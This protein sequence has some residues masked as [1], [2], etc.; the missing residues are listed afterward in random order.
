MTQKYKGSCHCGAVSYEVET[1][2]TDL[3]ACN[4]SICSR[5]GSLLIFVPDASFKL[6][7]GTAE[8]KN[9]QFGAK[10]IN[11]PFCSNCGVF[12][13]GYGFTPEG[14]KIYS[15]NAPC[16]ENIDLSAYNVVNYDGKSL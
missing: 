14:S 16:L 13:F 1:E 11:H 12:S 6:L 8:L 9:Y 2:I 10:K 4:C 5:K 15:I 7:S 3:L